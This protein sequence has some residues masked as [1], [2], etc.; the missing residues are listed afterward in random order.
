MD[1]LTYKGI[2]F[3]IFTVSL[4]YFFI[5]FLNLSNNEYTITLLIIAVIII[6]ERLFE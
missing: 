3:G 2:G 4:R 5:N 1:N 6:I